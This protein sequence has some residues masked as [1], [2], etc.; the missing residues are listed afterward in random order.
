MRSRAIKP[1]SNS[2][3]EKEEEEKDGEKDGDETEP[4]LY[5]FKRRPSS[6]KGGDTM[7]K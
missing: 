7:R 1:I 5:G 3:R 6:Y 2:S 4:D